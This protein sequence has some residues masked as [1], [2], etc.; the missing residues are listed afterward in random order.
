MRNDEGWWKE[1][2]RGRVWQGVRGFLGRKKVDLFFLDE[3]EQIRVLKKEDAMKTLQ[4]MTSR[5]L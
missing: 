5:V 3:E 2:W 4:F 1:T